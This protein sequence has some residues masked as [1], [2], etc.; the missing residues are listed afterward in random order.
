MTIQELFIASNQALQKVVAQVTPAQFSMPLTPGMSRKPTDLGDAL[1]YHTYDDA[2]VPDVLA[3]KT[4]EE[5][6]DV[7]ESLLA[8]GE[9]DVQSNYAQYSQRAI[10]AVRE[11]SELDRP[12][13]LS[14]G[15]FSAKEYLQHI[16]T[17]RAFRSYDIAK[18]IGID[19]AMDPVLVQAL[20][21]EFT[22]LIDGYRQMGVFP[23]AIEVAADAEPQAKLLA[24]VG[25]S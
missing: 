21:D 19:T 4:K 16:V 12:V 6:G 17:F 8:S 14:Y 9:A 18:M 10:D 22:P 7:Y 11:F 5:V 3:G 1:R 25:R 20:L 13:H 24:M 23:P 2:W 15:D